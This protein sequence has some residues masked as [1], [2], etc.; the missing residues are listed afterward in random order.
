MP[1]I[2]GIIAAVVLA[3]AAFLTWKNQAAYKAELENL[4]TEQIEKKTTT[5]ELKAEQKRLQDAEDAKNNF[6]AKLVET[7]KKLAGSINELDELN[8]EVE[9][10]KSTHA[11]K[12]EQIA[13]A[14]DILKDLPSAD[15]LIPKLKR[16]KAQLV[17]SEAGIADEKMQLAE[18]TRQENDGKAKIASLEQLISNYT[19][20]VSLTSLNTSISAVYRSWGFVILAGGDNE[21]VVP[22]STLDVIRD[23]AVI[24]KLKVTAVE[25]GRAAADIILESLEHGTQLQAGDIVV[26]EKQQEQPD[27]ALSS[28]AP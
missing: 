10:L 21:G 18:L 12:E 15:E 8:K 20:G 28:Y 4:R 7:G 1:K 26:A 6:A 14:K 22:G 2:I 23:G 13:N 17:E 27:N 19:Q 25:Q 11:A 9:D 3:I 16:L 24:A 5:E